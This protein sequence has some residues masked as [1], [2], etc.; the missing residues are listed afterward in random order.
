MKWIVRRSLVGVGMGGRAEGLE[1]WRKATIR[2]R[3]E[4]EVEGK[5][6]R[7]KQTKK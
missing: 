1:G 6:E 3:E 2:N 7:S 5:G 4:E